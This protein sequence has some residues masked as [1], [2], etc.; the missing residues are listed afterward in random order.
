MIML[1]P[2]AMAQMQRPCEECSATGKRVSVACGPCGGRK[3]K[4]QEKS[5]K[6]RIVPGMRPGETL[7]FPRECS[8][9]PEFSE[10]G[11]VHITLQEADEAI[12]FRRVPGTDDLQATLQ[13]SLKGSLLGCTETVQTH[14]AHPNG[15]V[16][17]VPAGT[18][19]GEVLRIAGEGMPQKSGGRGALHVTVM[20]TVTSAERTLLA[21]KAGQLAELFA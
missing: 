5:L 20:I 8:D 9:Q 14:P 3:F 2:G 12:Q 16:V 1:G 7:I 21:D 4:G 13:I 10:P 18:Q 19:N 6:A 15:L 11:D 17:V